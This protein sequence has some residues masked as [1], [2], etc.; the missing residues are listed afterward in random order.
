MKV[1]A[2]D[3]APGATPGGASAE[4]PATP[5]PHTPRA[6]KGSAL[7]LA[8][9]ELRQQLTAW[10]RHEPGAR[11]GADPEELHQLRVAVRRIE[12][13]LGLFKHQL[14]PRLLQARHGAKGVLRTLGTARDFDVQLALLQRY[15][16]E[17]PAA[18]RA[19]AAPLQTRLEEERVRARSK[20]TR[21]LDTEVTRHWL[22]TISLASADFTAASEPTAVPA[23][24]VLPERVRGR[25]KKLKKQVRKLDARSTMEDYHAVR[26]RAKQL[27][28]ALEC[29]AGMFGKPADEMLKALR[30]LQDCLGAQQDAHTAK[31]R[32][33]SIVA[34][35]GSHLPADTVFLMGR[36]AEHHVKETA[37]AR[38]DLAGAWRRV[39]GRRW[40]ALSAKMQEVSEKSQPAAA[41]LPPSGAAAAGPAPAPAAP[42][43]APVFAPRTVRH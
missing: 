36:L 42:E 20:M 18:E 12:A 13:T 21:A 30:R 14:S 8:L 33:A 11:L 41:K 29:G 38:K 22:E 27:R 10:M 25:F 7:Q 4:S 16:A 24:Q 15:C 34:D 43:V 26:R 23:V 37:R 6:Q 32:L 2:E 31:N 19:A 3:L 39:R 40:K 17:L 5:H 28:Y 9:T 35:P 1:P